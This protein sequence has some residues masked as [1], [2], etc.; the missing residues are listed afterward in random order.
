MLAL[1]E[2]RLQMKQY[3]LFVEMVQSL[4]EDLR[5][6]VVY[7]HRDGFSK[8]KI[9]SYLYISRST[10]NRIL[11][12]YRRWGCVKDPLKGTQGRRKIFR[13]DDMEVRMKFWLTFTYDKHIHTF[14]GTEVVGQGES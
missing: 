2:E 6:R 9:S 5:W 8:K 12:L 7:L 13:Y 14:S 1:L 4:S 3:Y 11:R 10:V